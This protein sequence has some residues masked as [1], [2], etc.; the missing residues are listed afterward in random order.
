MQYIEKMGVDG[1]PEEGLN[2]ETLSR[3]IGLH[4]DRVREEVST[5]VEDGSLYS[6]GDEDQ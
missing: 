2:L 4:I 6:T 3:A 1:L 5:L